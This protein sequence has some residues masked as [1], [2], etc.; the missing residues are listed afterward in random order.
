[1]AKSLWQPGR[2]VVHSARWRTALRAWWCRMDTS[3]TAAAPA[4][5]G[6]PLMFKGKVDGRE[7]RSRCWM[8]KTSLMKFNHGWFWCLGNFVFGDIVHR[9]LAC[10]I[11]RLVDVDRFL[12]CMMIYYVG[13]WYDLCRC[14]GF[15]I[16]RCK[17]DLNRQDSILGWICS[18]PR[19][20]GET[21]RN[22]TAKMMGSDGFW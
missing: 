1:M 19:W 3:R 17:E 10:P 13:L 12:R 20:N 11:F 21:V 5:D 4:P 7:G 9:L 18:W 2:G 14:C 15:T 16:F 22:S 8:E 6:S